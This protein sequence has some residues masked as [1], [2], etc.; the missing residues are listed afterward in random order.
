MD[1]E[2]LGAG[3]GSVCPRSA[4][5]GA[6]CRREIS[7]HVADCQ[8]LVILPI[9]SVFIGMEL[10]SYML[11]RKR[12]K[13]KSCFSQISGIYQYW[14]LSIFCRDF[15]I[16]KDKRKEF[17]KLASANFPGYF[18]QNFYLIICI[19]LLQIAAIQLFAPTTYIMWM[20]GGIYRFP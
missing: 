12:K 2:V 13:K 7:T 16:Y 6:V 17:G 8:L 11:E 15:I 3:L 5:G 14:C 9:R 1:A 20:M 4:V 18:F 19:F 10:Y